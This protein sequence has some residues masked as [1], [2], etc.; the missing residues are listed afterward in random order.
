MIPEL[1][2]E[3]ITVDNI[4]AYCPTLIANLAYNKL[5]ILPE[6]L[7]RKELSTTIYDMIQQKGNYWL[8]RSYDTNDELQKKR[9]ENLSANLFKIAHKLK[10][11]PYKNSI[12]SQYKSILKIVTKQ[13]V[14]DSNQ[15]QQPH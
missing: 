14:D 12:Y 8:I 1:I 10:M 2:Y 7:F 6:N 4:Y 3:T 11:N 5:G 15:T 9:Y 13:K